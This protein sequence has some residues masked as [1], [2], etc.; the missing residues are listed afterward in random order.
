MVVGGGRAG[1]RAAARLCREPQVEEVHVFELEGGGAG[2]TT[3][4][5][6]VRARVARLPQDGQGVSAEQAAR[7]SVHELL[8]RD[9]VR[10][11]A[12]L[13]KHC[14]AVVFAVAKP[15]EKAPKVVHVDQLPRRLAPGAVVVD[16]S[17]DERGAIDDPAILP[18]WDAEKIIPHLEHKLA[19]KGLRYLARANM[20][21]SQARE[22]TKAHGEVVLPYLA[23]LL[24]LCALEHG[25]RGALRRLGERAPRPDAPEPASV[26]DAELFD[27]LCQDLRNGL[28]FHTRVLAGARRRLVVE[29]CVADR[30]NLLPFLLERPRGHEIAFECPMPPRAALSG[31]AEREAEAREAISK[32]PKGIRSSLETAFEKGVACTL[33]WHP[34]IDGR[35]TEDAARALGVD[36]RHVLKTLLFER[37][38]GKLVAAVCGGDRHVDAARLAIVAGVAKVKLAEPARVLRATHHAAGGVP[39][40]ELFALL[41]GCVF[42]AEELL[43]LERV[44]AS[45]G[46][47][48]FGLSFAP[49]AL[50]ELGGVV[51]GLTRPPTRLMQ[52]EREIRQRLEAFEKALHR[53]HAPHAEAALRA[54]DELVFEEGPAPRSR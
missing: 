23:A 12:S 46:S 11:L 4:A 50:R 35:E 36:R 13:D 25:P 16:I 19:E 53:D 3:R 9:D 18:A 7:I 8:G 43:G 28:A 15:G 44:Y 2:G 17:I 52:H 41:P 10:L 27:A 21:R 49:E 33:L 5:E 45:A 51:A 29:G 54:L 30:V 6:Q 32:L 20:P 40:L 42:V 37:P 1:L 47:E 38:D 48:Y 34:E 22:A 39:T 26:P 31:N 14:V 24:W